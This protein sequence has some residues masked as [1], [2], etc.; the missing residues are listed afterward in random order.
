[1]ASEDLE[2]M[3][4]RLALAEDYAKIGRANFLL[5]MNSTNKKINFLQAARDRFEQSRAVY[6][7]M[8]AHNLKTNPINESINNLTKEIARCDETMRR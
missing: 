5:A 4:I 1:M 2:N 3:D 8:Q 7:D 6:S